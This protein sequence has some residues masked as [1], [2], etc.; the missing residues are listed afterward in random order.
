MV[1]PSLA[2]TEEALG[3]GLA[4]RRWVGAGLHTSTY[5]SESYAEPVEDLIRE[6]G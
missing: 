2:A 1:V 3:Y 4:C 6:E 5:S